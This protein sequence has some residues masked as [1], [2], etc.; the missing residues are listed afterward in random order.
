MTD[1]MW[2]FIFSIDFVKF[3]ISNELCWANYVLIFHST[4]ATSI[5][6]K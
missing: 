1:I 2:T 4:F 5:Y 3:H 6:I